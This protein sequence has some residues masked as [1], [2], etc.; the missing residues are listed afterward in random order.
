MIIVYLND[1]FTQDP[2]KLAVNVTVHLYSPQL[3]KI[4][5]AL[6]S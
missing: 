1:C 4:M 6:E 3:T 2:D 5:K